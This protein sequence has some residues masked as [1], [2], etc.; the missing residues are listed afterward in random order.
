LRLAGGLHVLRTNRALNDLVSLQPINTKY[1][2]DADARRVSG[3]TYS[4]QFKSVELGSCAVDKIL[5]RLPGIRFSYSCCYNKIRM[6]VI[7]ASPSAEIKKYQNTMSG[8][9]GR[10]SITPI[11]PTDSQGMTSY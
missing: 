11:V 2:R 9:C 4:H 3:S 1:N 5:H 8:N 6:R 10:P 7:A